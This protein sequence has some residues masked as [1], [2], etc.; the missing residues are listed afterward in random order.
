[1][2]P[3][4]LTLVPSAIAIIVAVTVPWFMFRLALKQ[5]WLRRLYDGRNDGL[6]CL[7]QRTDR[8]SCPGGR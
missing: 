2:P 3:D 4:A 5:D 1:V 8:H 7:L 6:A